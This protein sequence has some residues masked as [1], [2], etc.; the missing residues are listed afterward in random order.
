LN[1][2]VTV[3]A[4]GSTSLLQ[5]ISQSVNSPF[6]LAVDRTGNL[7]VGNLGNNTV[8][9]YAPGSTSVLRTISQGICGPVSLAFD[10]FDNLY[11]ANACASTVTVYVR[12]STSVLRTLVPAPHTG[13]VGLSG[14][15]NHLEERSPS[16]P[17]G[18]CT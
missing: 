12:Q 14:W 18:S 16:T 4:R 6:A 5:T 17:R 2:T 3:Y 8:T 7:Y 15:W 1:G 11:V 10:R 9:V 13:G